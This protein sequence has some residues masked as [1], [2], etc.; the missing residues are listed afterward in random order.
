M[1]ESAP[2][3]GGADEHRARMERRARSTARAARGARALPAIRLSALTAAQAWVLVPRR[4]V[5]GIV[6]VVKKH[7]ITKVKAILGPR[8][9]DDKHVRILNRMISW[10]DDLDFNISIVSIAFCQCISIYFE[11]IW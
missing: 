8:K 10:R 2:P 4:H 1:V 9:D 11:S 7:L 6:D 5:Q 3:E